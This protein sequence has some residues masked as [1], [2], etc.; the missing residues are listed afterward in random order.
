MFSR[1]MAR[2]SWLAASV[3]SRR[4]RHG[5]G[6]RTRNRAAAAQC[7]AAGRDPGQPVDQGDQP[8]I[9]TAAAPR[10]DP[11]PGAAVR[12]RGQRRDARAPAGDQLPRLRAVDP[13]PQHHPGQ[14]GRIAGHPARHQHRLGRLDRLHLC[15]RHPV[16]LERQPLQRRRPRRRFRHVRRRPD[17]GAARP[18][19][20]ALRLQCAWRHAQVRH[21]RAGDR[22]SS[23]CAARPGSSSSTAATPAASA[24]ACVNMPLGDHAALRASGFYPAQR[25]AISTPPAA[26]AATSTA[27]DSYGGRA[28][29]L[30]KPIVQRHRPPDGFGAGHPRRFAVHL[31]GQSGDPAA[32]QSA[33]RPAERRTS[34]A[35]SGSPSATD[36]NYRLYS[37]TLN[38]DFG[39]SRPSPR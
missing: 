39:P 37:G 38:W 7:R 6:R 11:D 35:S 20:H 8:I 36:V 32:D 9:V 19:G 22:H 27:A 31:R 4:A 17:R 12:L 34:P 28:S 13:G 29:L 3:A 10:P 30:L 21:R 23:S 1:M 25:P 2:R 18:A 5:V 14:S 16:R 15:R 33:H 26:P 24:M